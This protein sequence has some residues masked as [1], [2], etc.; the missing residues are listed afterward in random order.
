MRT[1]KFNLNIDIYGASL[2]VMIA[3][4][5][6]KARKSLFLK[7]DWEYS[8]EIKEDPD[9]DAI[10]LFDEP[11]SRQYVIIFKPDASPGTIAHEVSHM[12]TKL[13]ITCG[14]DIINNDEPYAYLMGHLVDEIWE[15]F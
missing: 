8:P 9:Y 3:K 13:L 7:K 6:E 11:D 15:R 2:T 12:V 1:R 4:D 5:I 10:F 14:V